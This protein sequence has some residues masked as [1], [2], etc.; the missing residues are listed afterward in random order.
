ML[1]IVLFISYLPFSVSTRASW[2]PPEKNKLLTLKSLC[3]D[4]IWENSA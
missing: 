3:Q 4:L 2:E 1:D